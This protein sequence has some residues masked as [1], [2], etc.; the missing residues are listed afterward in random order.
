MEEWGKELTGCGLHA[1]GQEDGG[2]WVEDVVVGFVVTLGALQLWQGVL[3]RV[4]GDTV[5]SSQV[6]LVVEAREVEVD[7]SHS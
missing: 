3:V 2:G 1:A 4:G 6:W 7:S 5:V